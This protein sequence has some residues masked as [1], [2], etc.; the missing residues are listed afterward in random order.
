[1]SGLPLNR[2]GLLRIGLLGGALLTT[3]GLAASLSGCSRELPATSFAMLR[4]SDLP[5]LRRLI[6]VLLAGAVATPDAP[7]VVEGTLSSLDRNLQQLSPA[8]AA[9]VLQLFD[10]LSLPLTRGPLTGIWGSWEA[11]SDQAMQDFLQRWQNAPLAL[12]QQ[13]HAVL[14]Q[15]VLMAW[16]GRPEAWA[17][18]GYPGPPTV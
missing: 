14:L 2:R 5:L 18:C 6:P 9:Q 17:Q 8:L 11:A 4:P 12:Q 10:L 3:S 13:G 16:Y 7:Q 15:L 1:M